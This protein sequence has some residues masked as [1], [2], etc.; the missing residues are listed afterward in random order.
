MRIA[1][2]VAAALPLAGCAARLVLVAPEAAVPPS[3]DGVLDDAAWAA[4]PRSERFDDIEGP[5]GVHPPFATH[6]RSTWDERYLYFAAEIEEPDVRASITVPA[7][8][9][10]RDDDFEVFLDP[11]GDAR[12]YVELELNA[13]GTLWELLLPRP[14]VERGSP[15]PDFTCG[16]RAA[17]QVLGSLGDAS[18]RDR[19]WTA[20]I[21]IPWSGLA[22]AGVTGP[23]RPGDSWRVNFSRVE[24]PTEVRD[25][26]V[27]KVPGTSERNWAW[28]PPGIVDMHRPWLWGTL[29]FTAGSPRTPGPTTSVP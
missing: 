18:D 17:V 7:E 15:A 19:G 27:R 10:Y 12:D 29:V 11:G 26:R 5:F 22:A 4:A 1:A 3:I 25:G 2:A 14:Y 28:S 21:A 24:W 6:V 16:A 9:V 23:P 8:V 13:F 20:E